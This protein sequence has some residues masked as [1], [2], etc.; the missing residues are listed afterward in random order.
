M[1]ITI[2][3][4]LS[5]YRWGMESLIT[6]CSRIY[7]T[8]VSDTIVSEESNFSKISKMERLEDITR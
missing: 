6:F 7:V 2:S 1:P 8:A 4:L 3:L 5:N